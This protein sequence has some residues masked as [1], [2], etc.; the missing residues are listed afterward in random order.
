LQGFPVRAVI[1]EADWAYFE[2]HRWRGQTSPAQVFGA[3]CG[4]QAAGINVI[5][6]GHRERAQQI[7]SKILYI[8]FR[9]QWRRLRDAAASI[10][11]IS[12][13]GQGE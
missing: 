6:A 12:T 9:R 7:A 10:A 4:Y 5:L 1:I 8:E 11:S 2:A 3:I 13:E